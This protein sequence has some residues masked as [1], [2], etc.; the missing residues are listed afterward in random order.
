MW[1][2]G[3]GPNGQVVTLPSLREAFK[4]SGGCQG[5][6]SCVRNEAASGISDPPRLSNALQMKKKGLPVGQEGVRAPGCGRGCSGSLRG[7]CGWAV[8]PSCMP[9]SRGHGL[10]QKM[11]AF[12]HTGLRTFTCPLLQTCRLRCRAVGELAHGDAA[13]KW[14]RWGLTAHVKHLHPL[15]S[16]DQAPRTSPAG[17]R[18]FCFPK[19]LCREKPEGGLPAGKRGA[20]FNATWARLHSLFFPHHCPACLTPCPHPKQ[21]QVGSLVARRD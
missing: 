10:Q 11:R 3:G 7:A 4:V 17:E 2:T 12:L 13:Q 6:S 1:L 14:Q 15:R 16:P 19:K 8:L 18:L 5:A 21:S 9:A 20:T